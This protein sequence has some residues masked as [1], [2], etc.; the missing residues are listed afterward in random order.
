MLSMCCI[1]V[2]D[3]LSMCFLCL[4]YVLSKSCLFLVYVFSI[5]SINPMV[6]QY[7]SNRFGAWFQ[8]YC[9]INPM[10]LERV[11]N[12]MC[13]SMNTIVLQ[14][15]SNGIGARFQWY[16]S[17]NQMVLANGSNVHE[18]KLSFHPKMMKCGSY[19]ILVL[20]KKCWYGM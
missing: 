9:C 19:G 10:E 18:S 11:F 8:W 17:M 13:W 14:Y 6:L 3:V 20:I 1:C 7:E 5:W 4:V 16:W 15:E 12:L 2:I